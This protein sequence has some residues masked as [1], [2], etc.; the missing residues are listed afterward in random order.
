MIPAYM[1]PTLMVVVT[2]V[3]ILFQYLLVPLVIVAIL[4]C[5]NLKPSFWT[6]FAVV[7]LIGIIGGK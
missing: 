2:V 4:E 5:F 1:I 7:I 3:T 6:C